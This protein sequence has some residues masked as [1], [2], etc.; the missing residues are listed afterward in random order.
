MKKFL[1]ILAFSLVSACA[2]AQKGQ[3]AVGLN[4]SYGTEVSSFGIGAK[5]QY[6]FTNALRGEVSFDYFFGGSGTSMWDINANVHYLFPVAKGLK[7][8]PLAGIA[9][10]NW[11]Y[12][13]WGDGD[14]DPDG[15]SSYPDFGWDDILKGGY[16]D[17]PEGANDG[18]SDRIGKIG[19]NLGC[20]VQYDFNDKWAA[21]FEVK[22]QIISNF[23]QVVLGIGAIYKF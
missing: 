12:W 20:G 9:Y 4:L 2:F 15:D 16:S 6:N 19:I 18:G 14:Y 13:G 1:F 5:G 10:T 22:Y 23:N 17:D 11:G 8:Y 21:N 7:I 3:K